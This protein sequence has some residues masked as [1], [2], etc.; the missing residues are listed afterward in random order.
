MDNRKYD[1]SKDSINIGQFVNQYLGIDADCSN[2]K[3]AGLKS[4]DSPFVIGV[5]NDYADKNPELVKKGILLIVI[6]CRKNKGTYINP[7]RLQELLEKDIVEEEIR[8]LEKIG[9][10]NL[11]E[12]SNYYRKYEEAMYRQS[13]L[14]KFYGLLENLHKEKNVEQ[15]RRQQELFDQLNQ[16]KGR[17]K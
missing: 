16:T 3:H 2:L 7:H 1:V 10:S 5:S 11:N 14:Q 8:E 15:I 12:I 4:F 6:D 9:I 13:K 17:R